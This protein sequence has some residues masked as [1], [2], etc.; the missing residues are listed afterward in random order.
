MVAIPHID[1]APLLDGD[2]ADPSTIDAAIQNACATSGFFLLDRHGISPKL[3]AS[4]RNA[5]IEYF[6]L[7][8]TVKLQDA[9]SR[10]NYR[11]YIPEAYFSANNAQGAVDLYEGYKLHTEIEQDSPIIA[12]CDL[13]GPNK[14]PAAPPELERLLSDYWRACDKISR[15]LICAFARI[16]GISEQ[17]LLSC[18]DTPLTNMT[19][20]HYPAQATSTT[21]IHAHKDTDAFTLLAADSSGDLQIKPRGHNEWITV[22]IPAHTLLANIGDMLEIWSGGRLQ[23]TPHR[24]V[25]TPGKAR[26]SFPYF[27]VPRHDVEIRPLITPLPDFQRQ[28]ATA[29][30]I[31]RSIWLSNWPDSA[32]V[33]ADLD[34]QKGW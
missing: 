11:G 4:I 3:I 6:A 7:D 33:A 1:L 9:V 25:G 20:L 2:G 10:N 19:L 12:Q 31:S 18:F 29:G 30:E 13:Y 22:T 16:L 17:Y 32:P 24:V 27:S 26:Y 23:S 8:K 21:G 15:V 34:P 14:W 28:T 5:L